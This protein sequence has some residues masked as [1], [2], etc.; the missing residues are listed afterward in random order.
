MKFIT[1]IT[2]VLVCV[3]FAKD[4]S[5]K[6]SEELIQKHV[7]EQ[8]EREK[9]YSVEQTFYQGSA[10]NLKSAEVNPESLKNLP[11][12]EDDDFNMDS[13]YD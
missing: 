4:T 10:Y 7:Q 6:K 3:S 9:R 8:I 12:I 1:L 2:M 13:V 5:L 11:E